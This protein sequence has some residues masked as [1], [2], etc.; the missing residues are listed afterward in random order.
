[1]MA[2]NRVGNTDSEED[3]AYSGG[4]GAIHEFLSNFAVNLELPLK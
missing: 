2:T 1:M 3:F 4:I